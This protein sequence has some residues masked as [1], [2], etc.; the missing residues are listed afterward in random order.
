ML[1]R[2]GEGTLGFAPWS[3]M[4]SKSQKEIE[5][6]RQFVVYVAEP[7]EQIVEQYGKMFGKVITPTKKLVL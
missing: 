3:P 4:I 7:D 1:F 6:K 5:I 2:S